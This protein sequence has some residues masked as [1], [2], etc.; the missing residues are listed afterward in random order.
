MPRLTDNPKRPRPERAVRPFHPELRYRVW[1][2]AA[3]LGQSEPKTWNDIRNGCLRVI[4]EGKMT[5]VPGSEIVRRSTIS[6]ERETEA[7]A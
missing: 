5:F 6:R 4:R 2:A 3:H 1:E 7:A